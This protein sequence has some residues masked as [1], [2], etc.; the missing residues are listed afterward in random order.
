MSVKENMRKQRFV[1][2]EILNK[3]NLD[4]IKDLFSPATGVEIS[5]DSN[6][7]EM[8]RRLRAGFPDLHCEVEDVFGTGD[9]VV[10]RYTMS[11]TFNNEFRGAAP[12]GKRF[13]VPVILI[14]QWR[15]GKEIHGWECMDTLGLR[16]QLGLIPQSS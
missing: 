13:E 14:S 4:I 15:D 5:A 2:E 10:T 7:K 1:F 3:G 16:Q 6:F 9:K 12:T 11:G 8:V